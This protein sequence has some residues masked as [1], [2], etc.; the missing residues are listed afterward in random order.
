[1]AKSKY[2]LIK[3]IANELG[4]S[5]TAVYRAIKYEGLKAVEIGGVWKVHRKDFTE[6]IE[7]KYRKSKEKIDNSDKDTIFEDAPMRAAIECESEWDWLNAEQT[8]PFF[9]KNYLGDT[10]PG[11]FLSP[12]KYENIIKDY[13]KTLN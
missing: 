12:E 11:V 6:F 13:L 9:E 4:T 1:M 7:E 3:E 10:T 5:E 8:D 2:L